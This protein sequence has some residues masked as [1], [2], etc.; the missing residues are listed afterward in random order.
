M[1]IGVKKDSM[2]KVYSIP[3]ITGTQPTCNI[4]NEWL[5]SHLRD[6]AD[7]IEEDKIELVKISMEWDTD[8][9][10]PKLLITAHNK[11]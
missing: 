7:V 6:L 1:A 8:Y 10:T 5:I 3:L 4:N 11:D 2:Y 9:K